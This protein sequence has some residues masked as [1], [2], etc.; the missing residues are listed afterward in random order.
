[1]LAARVHSVRAINT[2]VCIGRVS[3]RASWPAEENESQFLLRGLGV[4][5]RWPAGGRNQLRDL[6]FLFLFLTSFPRNVCVYVSVCVCVCV[7]VC[8]YMCV[9][10]YVCMCVCMCVCECVCVCVW[11]Y[12]YTDVIEI[13]RQIYKDK[14]IDR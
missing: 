8:V 12:R 7:C 2:G 3:F 11:I 6:R 10:V 9:C 14:H 1:M 5:N 13:D 4:G